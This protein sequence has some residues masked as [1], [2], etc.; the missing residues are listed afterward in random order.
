MKHYIYMAVVVLVLLVSCTTQQ[1][2]T[3]EQPDQQNTQQ[4]EETPIETPP[5]VE[6]TPQ[7]PV[8]EI[9]VIPN[10]IKEILEK[11]K[12]KL[13]SYSYNYKSPESNIKYGIYIKGSN[14][15]ITLPEK[16]TEEQG[17]F[18]NTVYFDTEKKTAQAYCI[19]YSSCEG[20]VGKIKDL[21]YEKAYI[22]TPLDW[23]AKVTEAKKI[24]QRQVEGRE[25]VYL[26]TNIGKITVESYYGFLYNIEDGNKVW[27]FTDAAFN[28]VKDSDVTAQ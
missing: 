27:E 21:D 9:I 10:D 28:S 1:P 18:Y 8:E 23:L 22:E 17:K 14:I 24:D 19:G 16:N 6:E 4:K 11:G 20:K 7:E 26:E 13:N 15:K 2:I 5:E 25:S 3:Q 12:T